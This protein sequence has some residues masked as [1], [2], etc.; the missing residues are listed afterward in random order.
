[1]AN[2]S[3]GAASGVNDASIGTYAW[4]IGWPG[5]AANV[6]PA[7]QMEASNYLVAKG[8]DFS[9]IP[10]TATITGIL[11]NV[12]QWTGWS[13]TAFLEYSAKLCIDGVISGTEMVNQ[14][15]QRYVPYGS[16][17]TF[18][19]YGAQTEKWGLNLKGS[20]VKDADFGFAYAI[21]RYDPPGGGYTWIDLPMMVAM[22]VWYVDAS[23]P[24]IDGVTWV[25]EGNTVTLDVEAH[26]TNNPARDLTAV[27][28]TWKAG[29]TPEVFDWGDPIE[30]DYGASDAGP[31]AVSV[32][33][34]NDADVWSDPDTSVEIER[35][36]QASATVALRAS[37]TATVASSVDGWTN[38]STIT[39]DT[40]EVAPSYVFSTLDGTT[41]TSASHAG[42]YAYVNQ[43]A[44]TLKMLVSLGASLGK[45][46]SLVASQSVTI[47]PWP[48]IAGNSGAESDP[49]D[50]SNTGRRKAR[51]TATLN[52]DASH[53]WF[54]TIK[55]ST[56]A[57]PRDLTEGGTEHPVEIDAA[58]Y[59]LGA[60]PAWG[61]HGTAGG[62]NAYVDIATNLGD[63]VRYFLNPLV[64]WPR[65]RVKRGNGRPP[66][67]SHGEPA[68]A[69]DTHEF[70]VGGVIDGLWT[71]EL[72]DM[73]WYS[74][75]VLEGISQSAFQALQNVP[76]VLGIWTGT[77]LER[78]EVHLAKSCLWLDTTLAPTVVTMRKYD[79]TVLYTV[80]QEQPE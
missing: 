35:H 32:R 49:M 23:A 76:L 39:F 13:A 63:T 54:S 24:E 74:A 36:A 28:V 5:S 7:N 12:T 57:S 78:C 77:E 6:G 61:W 17:N 41:P 73:G 31:F 1:M 47:H 30:H 18:L 80:V 43:Y 53:A 65:I 37:G 2:T 8:F 25:T 50:P 4:T 40:G 11:V 58:V 15:A 46:D 75:E 62:N 79:G 44:T 59:D 72:G 20:D 70:F 69:L 68:F 66:I 26:D 51:I 38:W 33:V 45:L 19:D 60:N 22:T 16:S 27:E 3:S 29:A 56:D 55:F 52:D 34:K 10:D 67:L 14:S 71:D 21:Q 48:I 64:D 42:D 9:S